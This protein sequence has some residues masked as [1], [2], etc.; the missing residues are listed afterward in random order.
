MYVCVCVCDVCCH[1]QLSFGFFS[2]CFVL[3]LNSLAADCQS[4]FSL[5]FSFSPF[6]IRWS[7]MI[8][9]IHIRVYR[10]KRKGKEKKNT[11]YIQKEKIPF[12]I[13]PLPSQ[14]PSL[15]FRYMHMHIKLTEIFV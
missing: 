5:F 10:V 4:D 15:V 1:I 2:S 3:P 14:L 7:F 8:N 6:S 9:Y 13:K 11:H 12:G